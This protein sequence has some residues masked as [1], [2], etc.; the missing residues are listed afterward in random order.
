MEVRLSGRDI[1]HAESINVSANGIYFSSSQ[2]I[3]TLTKVQITLLLPDEDGADSREHE[4]KCEGVVVRT[5]P[6]KESGGNGTYDIAC[7][8]TSISVDDKEKLETYIL[9]QLA[10]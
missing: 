2:F 3:E 7:Y 10:F 6:E 9:K 4:I 1:A 8:F 5:E